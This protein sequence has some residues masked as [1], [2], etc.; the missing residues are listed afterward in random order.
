MN[1]RPHCLVSDVVFWN[2]ER[3]RAFEDAL[4]P[5]FFERISTIPEGDRRVLPASKVDARIDV[6]SQSASA[7]VGRFGAETVTSTLE[8]KGL[9]PER[10]IGGF[11][12]FAPGAEGYQRP[13]AVRDGVAV[14]GKGSSIRM[15]D[16]DRSAEIDPGTA[17]AR[18]VDVYGG[19][20]D[21]YA[22]ESE[23]F[24]SLSEPAGS[25]AA[26]TVRTFERVTSPEPENL[27][28]AGLV[29]SADGFEFG[30]P[31]SAYV[32]EFRF[33]DPDEAV[34]EPVERQFQRRPGL[35]EFDDVSF[36]VDGDTVTARAT[37][38]TGRF[39]G[40]LPGDPDDRS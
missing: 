25:L 37:M 6:C 32:V 23:V 29:G 11:E 14:V 3:I 10:E 33:G 13:V 26:G 21:G 8:R 28:F 1:G 19:D 39:D 18:V 31:T 38:A 4:H 16:D 30:R 27:R 7:Y 34:V 12:V 24:R 35:D 2:L 36:A 22:A 9:A 20:R 15:A 40:Y 5:A 17:V